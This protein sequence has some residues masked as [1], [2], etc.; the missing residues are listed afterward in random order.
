MSEVKSINP[1][2]GEEV[3]SYK[4][5]NDEQ[6][7]ASIKLADSQFHTWK[8]M[9]LK[10]RCKLIVNFGNLLRTQCDELAKL[11]TL[12]MGKPLEQAKAEVNKCAD[13][14]DFYAG[15]AEEFLK[16]KIVQES[17]P[18]KMISYQPIGCVL[19]VM[20]WNFPYWQVVRFAVPTLLAG[21]TALLKH[22]SNVSGCALK[23]EELLLEAGLAKG[24]FQ[25]LVVSSDSIEN[26]INNRI[27]KAVSL[28]GSGPAGSAVGQ[29][30]GKNIKKMVLELGGSD[31]YIILEDADLD[32]AAKNC[33]QS[34]LQNNG[35][36][37][38]AAKRFIVH[39]KVYDQFKDKLIKICEQKKYGDPLE[40]STD[41]GPLAKESL[42]KE[43]SKQVKDSVEGGAKLAYQKECTLES[44]AF[45]PI[46]ILED[47][48]KGTP[49]YRD[50]FFGP[51]FLLFKFSHLDEALKIANDS[52]F[53]LGGGVFTSNLEL[54]QEIAET[55]IDSGSVFVN[56]FTKSDPEM[57]FGGIKDSGIGRELS[58]FG[59]HEFVNI[60]SI[61]V[62]S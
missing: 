5:H 6:I 39:E 37:C 47:I 30:A 23:I 29:T 16:P 56:S 49:A 48:P 53:G 24:I 10:E 19:A 36:S 15:K 46:T 26:I 4:I 54:G 21:N 42:A 58:S 1:F 28:T 25:T 62:S 22:A 27:I 41:I 38:I 20:P 7:L 12:E 44:G 17:N 60:K 32:N 14:C 51:V 3:G 55:G 18:M 45:S 52:D 50:E 34:R 33:A 35:Q 11:A 2:N 43:L 61:S 59:I 9:E 31:P 8:K 13:L 57:P 40:P